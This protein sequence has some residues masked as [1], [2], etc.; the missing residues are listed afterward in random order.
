MTP[1]PRFHRLPKPLLSVVR[2]AC[3]ERKSSV[4]LRTRSAASLSGQGRGRGWR[5][6]GNGSPASPARGSARLRPG[7]SAV[8][9][10]VTAPRGAELPGCTHRARPSSPGQ[11]PK[12]TSSSPV[13]TDQRLRL[14]S[15][16]YPRLS[17]QRRHLLVS[18]E[19]VASRSALTLFFELRTLPSSQ[20][21]KLAVTM[22]SDAIPESISPTATSRSLPVTGK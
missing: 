21:P 1:L 13:R 2:R 18:F 3:T 9:G 15:E 17:P 11:Q 5:P 8:A 10:P 12:V 16:R 7:G 6:G 19:H 22:P 4:T 14:T 20:D